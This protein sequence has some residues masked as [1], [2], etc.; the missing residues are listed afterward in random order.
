MKRLF[1][2]LVAASLCLPTASSAWWQSIQQVAVSSALPG[3]P[4][5]TARSLTFTPNVSGG[6]TSTLT[7]TGP[8]SIGSDTFLAVLFWIG[9]GGGA[10]PPLGTSAFSVTISGV[11]TSVPANLVSLGPDTSLFS[12]HFYVAYATVPAGLTASSLVVNWSGTVS[13]ESSGGFYSAV[14]SQMVSTT[15]TIIP[16]VSATSG[17]SVSSGTFNASAGAGVLAIGVTFSV[18]GAS[19]AFTTPN[20]PPLPTPFDTEINTTI[21]A[22]A[23]NVSANASSQIS[24]AAG[25]SITGGEADIA[26][27]VFR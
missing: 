16:T 21:W 24:M 3:P 2:L 27:V 4:T 7:Y 25:A 18:S 22:Q 19:P 15:P 20:T 1:S 5:F 17:T 9:D 10:A 13:N 12:L 23:S 11:P 26:G 8:T 6:G 14:A